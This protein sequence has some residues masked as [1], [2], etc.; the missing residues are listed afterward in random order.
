VGLGAWVPFD[1]GM[2]RMGA[3]DSTAE[4]EKLRADLGFTP[5]GFRESVRA[6]AAGV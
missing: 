5:A 1:E 4:L 6:Y 3:E 2:A